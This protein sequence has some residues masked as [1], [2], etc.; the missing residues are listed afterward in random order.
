M[1]IQ[2]SF[3]SKFSM[4]KYPE[5]DYENRCFD[6]EAGFASSSPELTPGSLPSPRGNNRFYNFAEPLAPGTPKLERA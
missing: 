2:R 4:A 3:L 5:T 1:D 6:T